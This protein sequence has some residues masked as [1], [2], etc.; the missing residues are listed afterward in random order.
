MY[1]ICI[2]SIWCLV[3]IKSVWYHTHTF[4]EPAVYAKPQEKRLHIL[5]SNLRR[6]YIYIKMF[7]QEIEY[8]TVN[9]I[10][11]KREHPEIHILLSEANLG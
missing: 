11:V 4:S 8:K 5:L 1:F 3:K 2:C 9:N 10:E 6:N 7:Y